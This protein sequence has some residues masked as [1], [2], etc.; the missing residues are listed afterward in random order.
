MIFERTERGDEDDGVLSQG[1]EECIY[2]DCAVVAVAGD[3]VVVV[4]AEDISDDFDVVG[5]AFAAAVAFVV[6]VDLAVL[7]VVLA[8]ELHAGSIA[9]A[10]QGEKVRLG[11]D[12]ERKEAA[13]DNNFA[14]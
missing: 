1:E 4:V 12:T 7:A 2:V 10:A 3:A 11:T 13:L 9:E 14:A 6:D 5:V 8:T